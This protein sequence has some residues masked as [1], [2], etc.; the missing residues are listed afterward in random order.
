M[1]SGD[2]IKFTSGQYKNRYATTTTKLYTH[3]FMEDQDWEMVAHGM[4]EYAGS[5]GSAFNVVFSDGGARKAL[6]SGKNR[7]VI[8]TEQEKAQE[9]AKEA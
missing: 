5:Y 3:R 6:H 4:G 1:K 2:L 9:D 8:V 7:F